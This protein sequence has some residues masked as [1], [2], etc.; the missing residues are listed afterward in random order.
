M[1]RSDPLLLPAA[2]EHDAIERL[3]PHR[4]AMCL[5]ARLEH[6]DARRIV[7]SAANHRDPLHPLRTRGGLMAPCAI[8]YA[9]QAMALHGALLGH[10]EGGVARPGYLASVRAVA[11]HVVRL[12]DLPA[13]TPDELRIEATRLAGDARQTLYAFS[14]SHRGAPLAD[15]RAAIFLDP[16]VPTR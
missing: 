13:A 11:L 14:V 7:C 9:A 16:A 12:D 15:G 5:L 6:C 8:E 1:I 3:I 2:L 4:G 10:A